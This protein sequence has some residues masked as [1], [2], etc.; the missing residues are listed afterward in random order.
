MTTRTVLPLHKVAGDFSVIIK[1]GPVVGPS[2][3]PLHAAYWAGGSR[4]ASM[5]QDLYTS[6]QRP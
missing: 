6:F 3:A 4:Q 2:G 5:I 1:L